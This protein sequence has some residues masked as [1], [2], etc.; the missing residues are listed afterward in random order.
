MVSCF[1]VLLCRVAYLGTSGY[2]EAAKEKYTRTLNVAETR[3]KIYDR[4]LNRLTGTNEKL[5]SVVVPTMGAA[6]YLKAYKTQ[7]EITEKNTEER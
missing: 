4:N 2:A 1:A 5:L 7:E 6:E 3:G